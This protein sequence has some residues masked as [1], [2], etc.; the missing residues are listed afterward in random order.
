M[1]SRLTTAS[2]LLAAAIPVM[3]PASEGPPNAVGVPVFA[4]G[5][6]PGVLPE[7]I[8]TPAGRPTIPLPMREWLHETSRRKGNRAQDDVALAIQKSGNDLLLSWMG[9]SGS[10]SVLRADEPRFSR[11]VTTLEDG[12]V[13]ATLAVPVAESEATITYFEVSDAETASR[14]V[15]GLGYEPRPAPRVNGAESRQ[16]L[17]WW[18]ST[19]SML[20]SYFASIEESNLTF[21]HDRPVR[22]ASVSGIVPST[23]SS[24]EYATE[25]TF[26]I[27]GDT[28]GG[29]ITIQA[30]GPEVSENDPY[31]PLVAP[32]IQYSTI[33]GLSWAPST[34]RFWV[35]AE[36]QIDEIDLFRFDPTR[37]TVVSGGTQPRISRPTLSGQILF[38][39][40][41]L[42][43]LVVQQINVATGSVSIYANTH[44][45]DFTRDILP[46]GIAVDPDGSAC[47]IADA[48]EGKIVKIPLGNS[49]PIEDEWGGKTDWVFSDPCGF[50]ASQ[51]TAWVSDAAG[52]IWQVSS[53]GSQQY[54]S[55]PYVAKAIYIDRDI[56][57]D[58][59]DRFFYTDQPGFSEAF[60]LNPIGYG[61]NG[62][63]VAGEVPARYLGGF[64]HGLSD[65]RLLLSNESLYEFEYHKPEAV[66]VSNADPSFPYLSDLQ[67]TDRVIEFSVQHPWGSSPAPLHLRLIDPPDLAPYDDK[68]LDDPAGFDAPLAKFPYEAN[69]NHVSIDDCVSS[70]ECG[71]SLNPDGSSATRELIAAPPGP[72]YL[73]IPDD[74]SGENFLVQVS[75]ADPATSQLVPNRVPTLGPVFTSWKRVFLEQDRMFRRGALLAKDFDPATCGS[76]G[77]EPECNQV[78]VFDW[79]NTFPGDQVVL[80]QNDRTAEE[81]LLGYQDGG[82]IANVV[83]I[84]AAPEP[85]LNSARVTLD[86]DLEDVG[87]RWEA[88]SDQPSQT[89]VFASYDFGVGKGA[90]LGSVGFCDSDFNQVNNPGSC[91]FHLDGRQLQIAY[92]DAF[93][94]IRSAA[95]GQT[96]IPFLDQS[97]DIFDIETMFELSQLWFHNSGSV[98]N[99]LPP[100]TSPNNHFHL[101]PTG[102]VAQDAAG[103][104]WALSNVSFAL[105]GWIER[106]YA[107]HVS[108][109]QL[110]RIQQWALSHEE[111]HQFWVNPCTSGFPPIGHRDENAWCGHPGGSCADPV[112]GREASIMYIIDTGNYLEPEYLAM[113]SNDVFRYSCS[114]L[115]GSSTSDP[116]CGETPCSGEEGIRHWT[117]PE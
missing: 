43:V 31:L 70:G 100:E 111:G 63:T 26:D 15:T 79:A 96:T 83:S 3:L 17:P 98:T 5:D 91:F 94:D 19:I 49:S 1:R 102:D 89:G 84:S 87:V 30:D 44:D 85:Y 68:N 75:K 54:Y 86:L 108:D 116:P 7:M 16:T 34:G 33:W 95:S 2:V 109:E 62:S 113:I 82:L 69:D 53:S 93:T 60:N 97:V 36:N 67:G 50:D 4:F 103:L 104:S 20:G 32:G 40:A 71:L 29:F 24:R 6:Q 114:D 47:Y 92:A 57:T 25:V 14:A 10:V 61:W 90:G 52:L 65:G 27:P 58:G 105:V 101:V 8:S 115:R 35:S 59:I 80:F 23:S 11:T 45:D 28:R 12:Y 39:D 73:K 9:Q 110:T 107:G 41:F 77:V 55:L 46:V 66:L 76:G 74:F 106:Y 42:G 117:D 112:V 21:M 13:S 78:I 37:T 22:S 51:G 38:V 64:V 48:S 81:A 18:G 88:S 72:F 56:S 99:P